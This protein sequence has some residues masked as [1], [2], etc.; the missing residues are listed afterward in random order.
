MTSLAVTTPL[1]MASRVADFIAS[2]RAKSLPE[3][4]A[5]TRLMP[6]VLIDRRV[7]SLD[8]T[9]TQALMQ[10]LLSVYS[11]HYLQ[12]VNISMNVGRVN[13]LRLLDKFTTDR[14]LIRSMGISGALSMESIEGVM[15]LPVYGPNAKEY[16]MEKASDAIKGIN[17]ESNLAVGKLLGVNIQDGD[18]SITMPIQV[19]LIP[20]SIPS[21]AII[22]ITS[23]NSLDKSLSGRWHA[24]RSGEIRF[25]KD[26]ILCQD[27]LAADRKALLADKTGTLLTARSKRSKNLLASLVSGQ[28]SPNAVSTMMVVSKATAKEMEL[29]LKGSL[30]N[31]KTR[32][33]YFASNALMMLVVVDTTLERFTMYQRGIADAGEYT[34][35]DIKA[36]S[37]KA[38]GVDIESVLK[39]YN[40]GQAPTL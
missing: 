38:N 3:Y 13:V 30:H 6:I 34:L 2:D 21:D 12:A 8:P 32:N 28:P 23:N 19:N 7:M 35:D 20:K 1:E 15:S 9:M 10:T 22:S 25:A 16:S 17:D 14:E 18:A 11:A 24:W 36:N 37:K 26:F 5:P 40:L 29:E 39:A 33:E 31:V 4:T 27:L